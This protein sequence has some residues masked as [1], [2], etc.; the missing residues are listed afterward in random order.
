MQGVSKNTSDLKV[1][2]TC[3]NT[4]PILMLFLG[5]VLVQSLVTI[6]QNC[7]KKIKTKA[8]VFL[9]NVNKFSLC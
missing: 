5:S 6:M 8:L 4:V 9:I 7:A 2:Q 3:T 1:H